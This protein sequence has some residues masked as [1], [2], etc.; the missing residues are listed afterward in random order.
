MDI[1]MLKMASIGLV[2]NENRWETH[3][4]LSLSVSEIN[5]KKENFKE[6]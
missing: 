3:N 5:R 4:Y 6:R 2:T 1:S